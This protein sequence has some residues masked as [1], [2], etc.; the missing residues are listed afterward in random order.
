MMVAPL[1]SRTWLTLVQVEHHDS[2]SRDIRSVNTKNPSASTKTLA[3]ESKDR[4]KSEAAAASAVQLQFSSL[5]E[6]ATPIARVSAFCQAALKKLIPDEFW[7]TGESQSL[8]KNVFLKNV[9]HFVRLRRF[10]TM[11]LHE[12][13]QGMKVRQAFIAPT[14]RIRLTRRQVADMGWLAPPGLGNQ[15]MSKTDLRKRSEILHEFLYYLV[16]SLL[17]PLIRSNFYVTESNTHRYRVLF[18][19]HDVW[20]YVAE[21]AMAALKTKM[22]EEVKM[23]DALRILDSRQ[24]GFSQVRLLPKASAMRPIMNLR[25]RAIGKGDQRMLGPSINTILSPVHAML[26]L[27]K[28]LKPERL[29]SAMFAVSDMYPRLKQFKQ[30]MDSQGQGFY[31]AKVDVQAAFDTI[32]QAAIVRLMKDLPSS[33]QYKVVKHVE[34]QPDKDGYAALS[35]ATG[36]KCIVRWRSSAVAAGD[37][38]SFLQKVEDQFARHKKKTLFVDG[39]YRSY[40]TKALLTLMA[41]HIQQNLV[42]IG[43]KYYRQKNGIPQGSVLSSALCNFFY[44]D[45]EQE[46]LGFLQCDDCLLLRL[47]DDFLL[48]TTD[49]SKAVGF[50]EV[51]HSGLPKYGVQVNVGKSLVNFDLTLRDGTPVPRLQSGHAFPY[52]GTLLDCKTLEI[53]KDRTHTKEIGVFNSL[54]VE[55]S[56][57]PGRNLQ[58]KVLNAFKIQSHQMFF[59]TYHNS[60]RT[61]F[62]N[63]HG[64]FSETATKMW[65]YAR[66][67][68]KTKK[69]SP[70]LVIG[71]PMTPRDMQNDSLFLFC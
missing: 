52:C 35:S 4:R 19:R 9:D 62:R 64:A 18:F 63:M 55:F 24:L 16:D 2:S 28:R 49:K 67:L 50:V 45:L 65:A 46:C 70:R 30:R 34:M 20:R 44:A 17:I 27:E 42:K 33:R 40:D 41:N 56:R 10:E 59:D 15:R 25:R 66:C 11:N 23:E 58:R 48:I 13:T 53:T 26:N 6:L 8:N 37:S 68:P 29:G 51:M 60:P 54:T 1:G 22:F 57:R 21:P 39:V 61:A 31:F 47:I 71:R 14:G 7:G 38:S 36:R 69:P 3:K 12:L 32:P 5:S 43:K